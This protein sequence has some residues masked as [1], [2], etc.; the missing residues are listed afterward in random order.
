ME[1]NFFL[2][3]VQIEFCFKKT[4]NDELDLT[5]W[6]YFHL[7]T[8]LAHILLIHHLFSFCFVPIEHLF[9]WLFNLLNKLAFI[10]AGMTV[11]C[12]LCLWKMLIVYVS[13]HKNV[14]GKVHILLP[15]NFAVFIY[16]SI[17][18]NE[19]EILTDRFYRNKVAHLDDHLPKLEKI[20]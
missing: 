11:W 5:I 20:N 3:F 12:L 14:F 2:R 15:R 4:P 8:K 19:Q 10:I 13:H 18:E 1:I 17:V 16:I 9:Q 7:L 6:E